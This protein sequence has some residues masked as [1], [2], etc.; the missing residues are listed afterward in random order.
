MNALET[1]HG[2]LKRS[3]TRFWNYV[4]AEDNDVNQV[5]IRQ[6]KL[7]EVWQE[8]QQIQAQIEYEERSDNNEDEC[9]YRVE[10]EE[11]YYTAI[12]KAN[13]RVNYPGVGN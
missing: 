4:N 7:K 3:L 5:I 8:F 1:R 9:Q 6:A 11:L 13:E 2:Q 12:T 10:F